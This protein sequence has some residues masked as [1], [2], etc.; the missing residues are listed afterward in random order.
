MAT[1]L[2]ASDKSAGRDTK[3][4]ML[5]YAGCC[6]TVEEWSDWF[7][8][9]WTQWVL[10]AKPAIPYFHA[11]ALNSPTLAKE[12]FGL[13]PWQAADKMS[14]ARR[15]LDQCGFV[16]GNFANVDVA[17]FERRLAGT[18][19]ARPRR[20]KREP[21]RSKTKLQP[22][23]WAFHRYL[24]TTVENLLDEF[25]DA[26]SVNFEFEEEGSS[27]NYDLQTTFENTRTVFEKRGMTRHAAVMGVCFPVPKKRVPVQAG[28]LVSWLVR[29]SLEPG[30]PQN[31]ERQKQLVRGRAGGAAPHYLKQNEVS[32]EEMDSLA[33]SIAVRRA[34][35]NEQPED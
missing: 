29:R 22:I 28:D 23:H 6:A 33:R 5:V 35:L 16:R 32:V 24:T 20:S 8:P 3:L 21:Q 18:V 10:K 34:G 17:E 9:A 7:I 31:V 14:E 4:G 1:F 19:V 13:E 12:E 11:T 15:V 26:E 2:A 27:L 25:P 30:T